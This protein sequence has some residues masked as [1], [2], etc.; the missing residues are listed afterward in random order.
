MGYAHVIAIV[1]GKGGVGKTTVTA[2]LA[3]LTAAGGYR[4]LAVDLDPQGNLAWDLGYQGDDGAGLAAAVGMGIPP[5]VLGN[6]RERLNVVAGGRMLSRVRIPDD[7]PGADEMLREAL[8]QV[9]TGYDLVILDCPPGEEHLQ[10][11]AMVAAGWLLIPVRLDPASR[12]GLQRVARVY[13]RVRASGNPDLRVLG[14]VLFDVDVSA[15]RMREEA[16]KALA[17]DLGEHIP[18]CNSAVRHAPGVAVRARQRHLLVH[19]LEAVIAQ[20]PRFYETGYDP[21]Q[22]VNVSSASNLA[23]DYQCLADE[24]LS[25][26]AAHRE[27]VGA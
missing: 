6:V 22:V 26:H 10:R 19:E 16:A 24:I 17:E 14:A 12:Q 7:D 18:V 23:R 1:N 25:L 4:V 3:G 9:V 11:A 2:Q 15:R 27:T 5:P 20:L 21:S 8:R 13:A